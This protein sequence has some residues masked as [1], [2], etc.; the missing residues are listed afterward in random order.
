MLSRR[1]C[2][3]CC[4][5]EYWS[6]KQ[7]AWG[8]GGVGRSVPGSVVGFVSLDGDRVGKRRKLTFGTAQTEDTRVSTTEEIITGGNILLEVGGCN[9]LVCGAFHSGRRRQT[10]YTT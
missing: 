5:M 10:G 9:Q 4:S 6:H 1:L 8:L 2:M 7:R 3:L